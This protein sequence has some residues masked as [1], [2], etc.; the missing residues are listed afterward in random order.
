MLLALCSPKRVSELAS[1]SMEEMKRSEHAYLFVL[2]RTKNRDF[3]KP[4]S[5]FYERFESNAN[6]CPVRNLEHYFLMTEAFRNHSRVL[7]SFKKPHNAV[8][9]VTVARWIKNTL[10][11][12]GIEG[13]TA[14]STRSASTSMAAFKGLS[15]SAILAAANWKANGS[16]FRKF[17]HKEL[18]ESFQ[19]K[20]LGARSFN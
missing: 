10:K 11:Y 13:Y 9:S 5:A 3:G 18:E 2:R 17:Y 12:C 16:T 7:L 15:S 20:I 8:S 1:F 6:L 14:H 4:H 19:Q